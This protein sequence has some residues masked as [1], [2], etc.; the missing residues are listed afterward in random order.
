MLV[1]CSGN[2]GS[3]Q[4]EEVRFVDA[5]PKEAELGEASA[6][7]L[8]LAGCVDMFAV[9]TLAIFKTPEKD[10]LWEAYS[11]RSLQPV[12]RLLRRGHG[13]DEFE[14]LPSCETLT[15]TD[16][17]LRCDFWVSAERRWRSFDLTRT[18]REGRMA[19]T[20][21]RDFRNYEKL[22]DVVAFPD[23][24]FLLV[25]NKD[26]TG[27]SRSLWA[28][29]EE[30]EIAHLG[31][32]NDMAVENDLNTLSCV[33]CVN[34]ERKMV[35]EAMLNLNQINLYSLKSDKSLTLCVGDELSDVAE[36]D[37]LPKKLRHYHY[38]FIE[39]H[40]N[41]FVAMCQDVSILDYWTGRGKCE[42]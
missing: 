4:C 37:N 25:M 15:R 31:N 38:G 41:Y 24:S 2:G 13:H 36:V 34:P 9:D 42:L 11:L 29:G 28:G 5:F 21:T 20:Q 7:P 22:S 1:A 32:L 40:E 18:L 19:W 27:F 14:M 17:A 12:G 30:H 35:A 23:S 3:V 6:L 26:Y 33:R 8:D 16:S 10:Y 39:S